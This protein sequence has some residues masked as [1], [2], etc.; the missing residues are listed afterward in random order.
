LI[1]EAR[2]QPP[3]RGYFQAGRSTWGISVA[4]AIKQHRSTTEP[5]PRQ[6]APFLKNA[7]ILSNSNMSFLM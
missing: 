6:T 1:A 7:Y 4:R 2:A 5:L 3:L